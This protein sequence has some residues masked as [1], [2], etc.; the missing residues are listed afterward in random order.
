M[1]KARV[2]SAARRPAVA[3]KRAAEYGRIDSLLVSYI[4]QLIETLRELTKNVS[5]KSKEDL[6]S[7]SA[8]HKLLSDELVLLLRAAGLAEEVEA[9]E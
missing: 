3:V 6:D 2:K 4:E 1:T 9:E 7:F 5:T 8:C